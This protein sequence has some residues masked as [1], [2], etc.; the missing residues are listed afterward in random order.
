MEGIATDMC[1]TIE[2]A[3]TPAYEGNHHTSWVGSVEGIPTD[4]CP[5][6]EGAPTPAYEGNHHT[7]WVGSVEGIATDMPIVCPTI[8]DGIM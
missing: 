5:T 7:S 2:G 3:P 8:E 1:P 6:I 4:M